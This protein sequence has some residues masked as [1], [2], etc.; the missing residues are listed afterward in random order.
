M[1]RSYVPVQQ[2]MPHTR[3][4]SIKMRSQKRAVTPRK[5]RTS[6]PK[7]KKRLTRR[8]A[9][10][11]E[12]GELEYQAMVKALPPPHMARGRQAKIRA[13]LAFSPPK[14]QEAPVLMAIC[15]GEGAT[16]QTAPEATQTPPA[17][18]EA[19]QTPPATPPEA[20]QTPPATPEDTEEEQEAKEEKPPPRRSGK[21]EVDSDEEKKPPKRKKQKIRKATHVELQAIAT[22]YRENALKA[23][24]DAKE[25]DEETPEGENI[26]EQIYTSSGDQC[27]V[28][29]VRDDGAPTWE[30][31]A[32]MPA[33][34]V[35]MYKR[36]GH[37]PLE[38]YCLLLD[39]Q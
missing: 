19:A 35:D 28:G 4:S 30:P 8:D 32:N 24:H 6:P 18:P 9:K 10:E 33:G 14:K 37:V 11:A 2:T 31:L 13:N 17:T 22:R 39:S 34:I 21:R 12:L 36:Q 27:L 1:P 26:V 25:S 29:W 38:T 23:L 16:A 5:P 15:N 20:A 7:L 3:S